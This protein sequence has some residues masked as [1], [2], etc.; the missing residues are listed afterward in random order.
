MRLV[1]G[2]LGFGKDKRDLQ[3]EAAPPLPRLVR[4]AELKPA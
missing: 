2:E 3:P 4:V 1:A